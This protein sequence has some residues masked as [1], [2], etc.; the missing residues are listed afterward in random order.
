LPVIVVQV[1][2]PYEQLCGA[3][4]ALKPRKGSNLSIPESF[5][6]DVVTTTLF[7]DLDIIEIAGVLSHPKV[8]N[9]TE[10]ITGNDLL[11]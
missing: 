5:H 1:L 3:W 6:L 2:Q 4:I 11:V 8:W 10:G 9:A 7:P